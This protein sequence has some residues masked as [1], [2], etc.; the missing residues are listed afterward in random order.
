MVTEE[1]TAVSFHGK[2]KSEELGLKVSVVFFTLSS[3]ISHNP[4]G[5]DVSVSRTGQ[6][7]GTQSVPGHL[8]MIAIQIIGH[9][10]IIIGSRCILAILQL[11]ET[12]WEKYCPMAISRE[13]FLGD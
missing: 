2:E 6:P 13:I 1:N 8:D 7:R 3:S 12:V 5:K 11:L 4:S 9:I 10:K